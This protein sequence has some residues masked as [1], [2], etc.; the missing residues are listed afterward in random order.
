MN[1]LASGLLSLLLS[2]CCFADGWLGILLKDEATPVVAEV[3]PNSPAAAAGLRA[4]DRIVALDGAATTTIDAFV[5]AI[6]AH[7]SGDRVKLQL[8]R[9]NQKI[10]VVVQLGERPADDATPA[11]APAPR[12]EGGERPGAPPAAPRGEAGARRPAAGPKPPVGYL[13][14]AIGDGDDGVEVSR[15]LDGSPAAAAGL[16]AGDLLL[17]WDDRA[18]ASIEELDARVAASRPG[19][20]VDLLVRRADG[21]TKLHVTLGARPG[22]DRAA[23]RR[24]ADAPPAPREAVPAPPLLDVPFL[25]DFA[26]AEA[27]ARKQ[28]R[29]LLVFYGA[30]W[31]GGSQA[32]RRAFIGP[33]LQPLLKRFICVQVD[34]ERD[35]ELMQ[36]RGIGDLPAI[37][38]VRD[39]KVTVRRSGLVPQDELAKLLTAESKTATRKGD[40]AG[41]QGGKQG[42]EQGGDEALK[43]ELQGLRRE[44]ED[45]RKLLEELRKAR[46]GN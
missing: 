13:G 4:G 40:P 23:P 43:Q 32:Q 26:A 3:I 18:I 28:G 15:V 9:D 30:S 8:Q 1:S 36:T 33:D 10:E 46:G 7:K 12:A 37:E 31:D 45:L 19:E 21:E 14:A 29:P 22:A 38:I 35:R 39:G 41:E 16:R 20:Q 25:T 34:A 42:G 24:A 17:K 44:V 6:R 11:P 5:D 27:R 2:F